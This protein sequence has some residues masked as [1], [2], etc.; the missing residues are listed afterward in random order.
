MKCRLQQQIPCKPNQ[1][2]MISSQVNIV[3]VCIPRNVTIMWKNLM[4]LTSH[5]FDD[6]RIDYGYSYIRKYWSV[7]GGFKGAREAVPA[8]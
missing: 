7:I 8:K 5:T 3:L 6:Y 2:D 1:P 4:G